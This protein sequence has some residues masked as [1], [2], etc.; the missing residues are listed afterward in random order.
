MSCS[1][2]YLKNITACEG[3]FTKLTVNGK[4]A[5]SSYSWFV[6]H[7]TSKLRT[8]DFA[9]FSTAPCVD[10]QSCLIWLKCVA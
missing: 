3:N 10:Q 7:I 9:G 4:P 5:G 2:E 1:K 8:K 6:E